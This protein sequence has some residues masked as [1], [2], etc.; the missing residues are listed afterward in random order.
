M[1]WTEFFHMGG[2]AFYVWLSY[3]LGFVVLLANIMIT[4]QRGK[5]IVRELVARQRRESAR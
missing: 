4:R 3:G 1:N 2:Y 5:K